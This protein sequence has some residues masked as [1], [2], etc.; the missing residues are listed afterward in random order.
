VLLAAVYITN[1]IVTLLLDNITLVEA[2]KRQV[3][4]GLEDN[5]YLPDIGHLHAI[6]CK[7]YINIPKERRIKSAK[8]ALY[9]KEG[10]LVGFESS[11]IYHIYLLGRA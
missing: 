10:F 9:T 4:L 2:F 8:L 3:Q 5:D 7:V 1:R 6:S 11:K